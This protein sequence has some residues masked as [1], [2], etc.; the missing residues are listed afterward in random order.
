MTTLQQYLNNKY[1]TLRDK[2]QVKE[3]NIVEIDSERRNRGNKPNLKKISYNGQGIT[4]LDLS[5]CPNLT[6]LKCTSNQIKSLDLS[7]QI[8]KEKNNLESKQKH[9]NPQLAESEKAK[10]SLEQQLADLNSAKKKELETI[11]QLNLT[12]Y[13]LLTKKILKETKTSMESILR[14]LLMRDFK[15]TK[16]YN[17]MIKKEEVVDPNSVL[18]TCLNKLRE[19]EEEVKAKLAQD[20]Q[21]SE[22]EQQKLRAEIY[23]L[24]DKIY[25]MTT[26]RIKEL[27]EKSKNQEKY[28]KTLELRTILVGKEN[29]DLKNQLTELQQNNKVLKEQLIKAK[30]KANQVEKL[31][32]LEQEIQANERKIKKLEEQILKN[33]QQ[34]DEN[35][36]SQAVQENRKKLFE[37][38]LDLEKYTP[39]HSSKP[40]ELM[41]F[42]RRH[43]YNRLIQGLLKKLR[44]EALNRLT[45]KKQLL[46]AAGIPIDQNL[47]TNY[48]QKINQANAREIQKQKYENEFLTKVLERQQS[49]PQT[50]QAPEKKA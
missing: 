31:S 37:F 25:I 27:E 44:E 39:P 47:F 34:E 50:I 36:D 40:I 33:K 2:Q 17:R 30:E 43:D 32:S 1:P 9:L 4:F 12:D 28:I 3:I 21:S 11:Q 46:E 24:V 45:A 20:L 8:Q 14:L 22:A 7:N 42:K 35:N 41:Y 29:K 5:N 18:F 16:E 15:L 48:Q 6:E 38:L 49:Q 26:E 19:L 23:E 13:T 10:K